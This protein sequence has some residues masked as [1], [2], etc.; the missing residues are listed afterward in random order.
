[1]KAIWTGGDPNHYMKAMN[2]QG[3]PHLFNH[4]VPFNLETAISRL[5]G[6][7]M[8]GETGKGR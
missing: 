2:R 6:H 4:H 8:M 3:G 5:E 7:P 1:M